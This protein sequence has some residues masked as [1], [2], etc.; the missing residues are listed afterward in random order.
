MLS[1]GDVRRWRP[2][3][4]DESE[5]NLKNGN[6]KLVGLDDELSSAGAPMG[7]DGQ[8]SGAAASAAGGKLA[9]L[10]DSLEHTVAEVNAA[11]RAVALASDD[12]TALMHKV[13]EADWQAR[14]GN[15][16][17]GDQGDVSDLGA[18]PDVPPEQAEDVKRERAKIKDEL[19]DRVGEIMKRARVVDRD[20]ADVL[21]KIGRGEIH[22][23][24]ATTL[25]AAATAGATQGSLHDELLAK[26]RV[27]PDPDGKVSWPSGA[28]GWIAKRFGLNPQEM[29]ASEARHLEDRG[30]LGAADAYGIYRTALH[31]AETVW[32]RKGETDGHSDAFR[33]AYW[34]AMLSHRFGEEWTES[35]TTAHERKPDDPRAHATAQAM[36][37]HNNE[38]GRQIAAD[39]PDA[40]PDE[41]KRHVKEAVER[42][43]MVVVGGDGRLVRSNEVALG[44]T[45]MA[46]DPPV[47][48]GP[49]PKV[50]DKGHTAGGYNYGQDGDTYGTYDG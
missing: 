35:Y 7:K 17:I 45:G 20:L 10:G 22:D 18:P 34:N 42:G 1:Y 48:D 41:L 4:L 15:F 21:M 14:A 39:H 12:V 25:A 8:W 37:L 46:I 31:D 27:A 26:Y 50:D 11:W 2:G 43:D 32:D 29:S 5:Q 13:A 6:E 23:G 40:G 24:G 16:A 28:I 44:E 49:V 47:T 3:P 19:L 9:L 33:H 38:V 36:D 30:W